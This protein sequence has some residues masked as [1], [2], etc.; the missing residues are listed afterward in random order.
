MSGHQRKS[1]TKNI[2]T[3]S[4]RVPNIPG[5]GL[6]CGCFGRKDEATNLSLVDKSLKKDN[7]TS[8]LSTSNFESNPATKTQSFHVTPQSAQ[9]YREMRT[10]YVATEELPIE[11]IP[12][13]P[14]KKAT[15]PS[16]NINIKNIFKKDD[17]KA[18]EVP[19]IQKNV[20]YS[21]KKTD[22]LL[23]DRPIKEEQKERINRMNE[24]LIF[25]SQMI[26]PKEIFGSI[27]EVDNEP[28]LTQSLDTFNQKIDIPQKNA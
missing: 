11:E 24:N 4:S 5:K 10:K 23:S 14:G 21:H 26:E 28:E 15:T 12:E 16:L 8:V 2:N 3:T 18:M 25:E 27:I 22:S 7:Q 6:F 20:R 1:S 19:N 9:T 13:L 17:T